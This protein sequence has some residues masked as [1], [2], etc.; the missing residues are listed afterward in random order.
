M[1]KAAVASINQTGPGMTT[2]TQSIEGDPVFSFSQ[3]P[4]RLCGGQGAFVVMVTFAPPITALPGAT[5]NAVVTIGSGDGAFPPGTVKVHGEVVAPSV[6]VDKTVLDF[7]D[8]AYGVEATRTLTFSDTED[9]LLNINAPMNNTFPFDIVPA[10]GG[11]DHTSTWIVSVSNSEGDY[12][13]DTVWTDGFDTRELP[14]GCGWSQT[15]PL[16][17]HVLPFDAGT[18][19]DAGADRSPDAP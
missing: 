3:Q 6:T 12:A 17:V 4:T 5:F 18:S 11:T 14:P 19:N 15:I 2:W 16:R 10:M 13:V 8:L 9:P 7:G 1:A